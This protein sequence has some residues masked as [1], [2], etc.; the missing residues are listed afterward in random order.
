MKLFTR[1]SLGNRDLICPIVIEE[2]RERMCFVNVTAR[3]CVCNC[4]L[5]EA[6][7]VFT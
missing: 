7:K 2:M 5:F 6:I 4:H 3:V 1:S